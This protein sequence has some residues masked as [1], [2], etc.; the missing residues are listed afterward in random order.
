M[1]LGSNSNTDANMTGGS[2]GSTFT[3]APTLSPAPITAMGAGDVAKQIFVRNQK[4]RRSSIRSTET[5]NRRSLDEYLTPAIGANS[6]PLR[7][8]QVASLSPSPPE[9][10]L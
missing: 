4:G 10:E 9:E 7:V 8:I 1:A 3:P 5:R 2:I 6:S